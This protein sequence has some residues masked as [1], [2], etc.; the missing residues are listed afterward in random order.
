MALSNSRRTVA[1]LAV[2]W[3]MSGCAF[4]DGKGASLDPA[5]FIATAGLPDDLRL[6]LAASEPAVIDPVGVAFDADGRMYV[7]EM[8]DYPTRPAGSPPLGQIKRLVGPNW[9]WR[10]GTVSPIPSATRR[11]P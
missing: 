1:A 11:L 2:T 6:E 9:R 10:C 4:G 7:V 8:G 5:E 3:V